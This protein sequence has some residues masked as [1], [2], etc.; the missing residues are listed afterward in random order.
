MS[1]QTRA[2][3][4][5]VASGAWADLPEDLVCRIA[6]LLPIRE[7][8]GVL[9]QLSRHYHAVS[10]RWPIGD[11]MGVTQL[12]LPAGRLSSQAIQ[13]RSQLLQAW[14]ARHRTQLR[15]LRCEL[16]PET[17][18]NYVPWEADHAAAMQAARQTIHEVVWQHRTAFVSLARSAA[19]L[20][21][22]QE[23][24]VD[25]AGPTG[26]LA[27]CTALESLIVWDNLVDLRI[28][29]QWSDVPV[30]VASLPLTKLCLYGF[31][32]ETVTVQQ[33]L[34]GGLSREFTRL[35]PT[36]QDLRLQYCPVVMLP[37]VCSTF[38]RLTTL[39]CNLE[40]GMGQLSLPAWLSRL[41]NLQL[42]ECPHRTLCS[43]PPHLHFWLPRLESLDVGLS[44][45]G[46]ATR[47]LSQLTALTLGHGPFTQVDLRVL[48]G[49][50]RLRE[51]AV[52]ANLDLRVGV[53]LHHA[54]VLNELTGLTRL[55]LEQVAGY[56]LPPEGGYLSQLRALRVETF[57]PTSLPAGLITATNLTSLYLDSNS[58]CLSMIW[59]QLQQLLPRMPLLKEIVIQEAH[60]DENP[61][62]MLV[63]DLL[64][65][66]AL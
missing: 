8:Y 4:R 46:H 38:S 17:V 53:M 56:P 35:A 21:A 29:A 60:E 19:Q 3:A 33:R 47:L 16:P 7:R 9:P 62:H 40:E 32:F 15:G 65:H 28:G 37:I 36:L 12:F 43:M 52:E 34:A 1:R 48:R 23:A 58:M 20:A 30:V 27:Q 26:L 22:A 13:Q 66:M 25:N 54:D 55:S 6:G 41:T 63:G 49:A 11:G 64:Q 44:D 57:K 10:L 2:A 59:E 5:R 39:T 24:A 61:M 42:L 18:L 14:L 45:L 50:T 31:V 51:L